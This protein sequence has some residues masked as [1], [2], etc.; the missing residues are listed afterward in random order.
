MET[1]TT[2]I[3]ISTSSGSLSLPELPPILSRSVAIQKKGWIRTGRPNSRKWRSV[4][5]GGG[6]PMS[7]R[8][9]DCGFGIVDGGLGIALFNPPLGVRNPKLVATAL[10]RGSAYGYPAG[11]VE[12][13]V[14]PQCRSAAR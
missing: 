13:E 12:Y 9:S 3:Q 6:S 7:I 8:G 1:K 10:L 2:P 5:V 14:C 11:R 4:G